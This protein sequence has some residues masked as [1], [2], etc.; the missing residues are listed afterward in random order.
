M[1][2]K[3]MILGTLSGGITIFL[4]GWLIYGI[5]ASNFFAI[6]HGLPQPVNLYRQHSLIMHLAISNF[7]YAAALTYI[8]IKSAVNNYLPAI[9]TGSVVGFFVSG[10]FDL[11][12][13]S[14][15]NIMSLTGVV[16]DIILFTIISAISGLVIVTLNR[17][18]ISD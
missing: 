7:C 1:S 10:A 5:L 9:I 15:T 2:Y 12:M 18:L 11:N 14:M 6:H 4:L 17:M 3:K 16:V 8:F 13:Y